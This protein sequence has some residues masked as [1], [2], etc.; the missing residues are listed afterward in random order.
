[1]T[2]KTLVFVSSYEATNNYI[3]S[4][5]KNKL[6]F[7]YYI[8]TTK[9]GSNYFKKRKIN[10]F[11]VKNFTQL[12]N[13]INDLSPDFLF[14]IP[15][16]PDSI[17]NKSLELANKYNIKSIT[18]V[19]NWFPLKDRFKRKEKPIK[20]LNTDFILVNDQKVKSE[21]KNIY[22]EKKIICTGNPYLEQRWSKSY[23]ANIKNKYSSRKGL[24]K[25]TILFISEPYSELSPRNKKIINPGFS[26]IDIL[27]KIIQ[28]IDKKFKIYIKLHP[29]EN[30]KK[31]NIISKKN[32]NVSIIK[33]QNIDEIIL[34]CKKIIGMGSMLLIEAGLI[35]N[36]VISFRP[37]ERFRFVGNDYKI[38]N[39]VKSDKVLK[40]KIFSINNRK[41]MRN[42]SIFTNSTLKI[43]RFLNSKII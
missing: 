21:L 6:K 38:T 41:T 26:E 33:N 7:R 13:K 30:K 43:I 4:I 11:E 31:Y 24:F 29:S 3:F 40:N 2:H 14:T 10:N 42:K 17:E 20:Y 5:I 12:E 23:L 39:L 25:D 27:G 32:R 16:F 35:R 36:D 22:K 15:Q 9:P 19:D 34:N 28:V 37:S 1:M 18:A 8:I